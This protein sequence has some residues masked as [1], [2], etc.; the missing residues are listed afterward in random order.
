[1]QKKSRKKLINKITDGFEKIVSVTKIKES[2]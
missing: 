1:M 2:K